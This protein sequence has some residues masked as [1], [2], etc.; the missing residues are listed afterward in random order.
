[1]IILLFLMIPHVVF[2][3]WIVSR[4][5][6]KVGLDVQVCLLLDYCSKLC[7]RRAAANDS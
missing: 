6:R 1:M 4:I 7:T 5:A 3:G 2:G